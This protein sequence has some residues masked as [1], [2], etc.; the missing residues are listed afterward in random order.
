MII[1]P[2]RE[3]LNKSSARLRIRTPVHLLAFG[4]GAGLLPWAPGT[5]GT[6]VGIPVYAFIGNLAP[7]WYG[8]IV[9]VLFIL[10][11]R[12]CEIAARELGMADHP[13]IVW[14]EI[15]GFQVTMF[16]APPGWG[17]LLLGFGLFRLFDIVKPYP[18][19]RLEKLPGGW[20]IM[21]DDVLAGIY[22]ML[23]LQGAAAWLAT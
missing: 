15:V 22:A 20:G 19:K 9:L 14:D 16:M 5:F 11:V 6:L 23:V 18:I 3:P 1:L 10:G 8:L 12:L 7:I 2:A 4:F 13:A 21:S 17:Y